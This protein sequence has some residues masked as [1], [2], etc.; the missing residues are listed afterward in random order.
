MTV[1]TPA[2]ADF[3]ARVRRSFAEQT[4]MA[5]LGASLQAVAPGRAEIR[6]PYRADLCQQNGF[7]HGGITT[8]IADTAA[9]YASY[10]LYAESEAILTSEFSQHFLAP[11][12]GEAFLAVGQVL[13]PGRRL[14]IAEAEVFAESGGKSVPIA[15]MI[16]TL[17]R[18]TG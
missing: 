3:E 6:L 9:G 7:L 16:A 12:R 11:A 2:D 17:I 1:F 10:S 14:V 15:K 8:T 13:K 5:T 4:A 18:L